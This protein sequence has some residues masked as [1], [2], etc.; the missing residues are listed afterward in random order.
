MRSRKGSL[1]LLLILVLASLVHAQERRPPRELWN[2]VFTQRRGQEFPHNK[3]LEWAVKGKK[4]GKALDI[5]SGEGR[6]ALFLASQGWEVTGIDIS[7][8][9]VR[10]TREAAQKRGLKL[11]ALIEDVDRYEYGTERWD[12]VVGMYMHAAITRNAAKIVESLKPGGLLVV[13][14]FHR[15]QNRRGLEGQYFGYQSNELLRVF[16]RLRAVHYEDVVAPA[17]WRNGQDAPIV[18]FLAVK[19]SAAPGAR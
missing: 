14:G 8:V 16:D 1:V 7:D 3:F 17:D 11:E 9:G 13:E 4:P 2:E 15:D 6:N 12:L 10:L 19:G 18:R 5:G